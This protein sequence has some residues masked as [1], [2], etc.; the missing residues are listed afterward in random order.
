MIR[1]KIALN[2]CKIM[3]KAYEQA[4]QEY[5]SSIRSIVFE[6]ITNELEDSVGSEFEEPI[7]VSRLDDTNDA[8]SEVWFTVEI[9]RGS[10]SDCCGEEILDVSN[11]Y[12]ENA[13]KWIY[14]YYFK[15]LV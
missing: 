13:I 10:S 1:Y 15:N 6:N 12:I 9:K 4:S 5:I 8:D 3:G 7:E 11:Y 14:E 2:M